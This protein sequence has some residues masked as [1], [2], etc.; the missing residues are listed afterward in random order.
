MHQQQTPFENIVGKE[1]IARK[2][3]FLLFPQC[4]QLNQKIVSPFVKIFFLISSFDAELQ[5]PKIGMRG[6]GLIKCVIVDKLLQD[7]KVFYAFLLMILKKSPVENNEEKGE[8]A[9][10]QHFCLVPQCF[11]PFP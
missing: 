9:S 6:K 1:E 11:L 10:N 2:E 3:Q 5:E 4:F 8:N 7:K